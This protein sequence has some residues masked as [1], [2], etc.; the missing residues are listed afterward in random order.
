MARV[1]AALATVYVLW[2]STYLATMVAVD[3]LPPL[4]TTSARFL[5]AGAVLFLWAVHKGAR[6][7]ARQWVAAAV[8]G[9]ALLFVGIGG[10]AWAETRVDSG[11]AALVV[12]VVPV[13][14]A[15]LEWIVF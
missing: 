4:L 12:S 5:L 13:W 15:L 6:P 3:T 1:W 9:A 2:G 7:D 8:S 14:V 10:I 11:L